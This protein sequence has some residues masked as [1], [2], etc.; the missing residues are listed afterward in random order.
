M[1]KPESFPF[2]HKTNGMVFN[3]YSTPQVKIQRDGTRTTYDSF[4][5]T[6]YEGGK[7]IPKRRSTWEEIDAL[8]EEVVAA[9]RKNDPQRIELSGRDRRVYLAA[10]EALAPI[11][12]D[13]DQAVR[14]YVTAMQLFAPYKITLPQAAQMLAD[15]LKK[16]GKAS[17]STAVDF[18]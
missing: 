6:Y 11:G 9:H 10:V 2:E 18:F 15:A 16:L 13:V 3:I 12:G 17:L 7:R 5:L 1:K 8:I 14:D 4:L